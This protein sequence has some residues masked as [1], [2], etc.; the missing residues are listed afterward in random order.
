MPEKLKPEQRWGNGIDVESVDQADLTQYTE[1][2]ISVHQGMTW[3]RGEDLV[4]YYTDDFKDFTRDTFNICP[5]EATP[6]LSI[7]RSKRSWNTSR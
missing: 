1:W 2:R 5:I 3:K 4:D 7:L 6:R